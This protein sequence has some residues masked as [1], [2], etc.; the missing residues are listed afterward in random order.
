MDV[1]KITE[2]TIPEDDIYEK[3][4]Q[5]VRGKIFHVTPIDRFK[6]IIKDGHI[7]TNKDGNLGYHWSENS[8]GRNRGY[9]CLFDFTDKEEKAIEDVVVNYFNFFSPRTLGSHIGFLI[10]PFDLLK[11]QLLFIDHARREWRLGEKYI[12]DVECWYPSYLSIDL[13]SEAFVINIHPLRPLNLH[14]HALMAIF[15]HKKEK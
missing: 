2:F 3:G 6:K 12:P 11:N 13:C 14:E 15:S 4:L 1:P 8:F 5:L 9:V 10:F 7:K